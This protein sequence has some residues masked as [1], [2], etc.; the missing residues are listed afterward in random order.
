M[1]KKFTF[2]ESPSLWLQ[3]RH[4]SPTIFLSHPTRKILHPIPW[5]SQACNLLLTLSPI[6]SFTAWSSLFF[7][8]PDKL[9]RL[10][11]QGIILAW[12]CLLHCLN[13]KERWSLDCLWNL[14]FLVLGLVLS[15]HRN[16]GNQWLLMNESEFW[17]EWLRHPTFLELS[18]PGQSPKLHVRTH[19]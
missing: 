1:E 10:T 14:L 12:S 16:T 2:L 3:I 15:W 6:P 18:S 13:Y 4:W 19:L 5:G 7:P 8:S 11:L 9:L 17:Q